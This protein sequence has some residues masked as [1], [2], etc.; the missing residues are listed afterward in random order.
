MEV[1]F[2]K[3]FKTRI[4]KSRRKR[5]CYCCASPI[6]KGDQYVNHSY[7]YDNKLL[8]ISLHPQCF[9]MVEIQ[10]KELEEIKALQDFL[11]ALVPPSF[12]AGYKFPYVISEKRPK[13]GEIVL[14]S[15]MYGHTASYA[16][17]KFISESCMMIWEN[18]HTERT[19]KIMI[20]DKWAYPDKS[21]YT[22]EEWKL[23]SKYLNL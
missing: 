18:V 12:V 6:E 8:N 3:V 22:I 2:R 5:D 19:A 11:G 13:E 23:I 10:Q 20:N 17:V 9:E 14:L 1:L 21:M 16:R 7:S 4:A 15:S